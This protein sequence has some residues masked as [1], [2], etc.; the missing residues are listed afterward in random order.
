MFNFLML[1]HTDA[2]KP[3]QDDNTATRMYNVLCTGSLKK[4]T[5]VLRV[6][7]NI[8][9]WTDGLQAY[10]LYIV[11][12]YFYCLFFKSNIGCYVELTVDVM[13]KWKEVIV[14]N[15]ITKMMKFCNFDFFSV[16]QSAKEL[17]YLIRESTQKVKRI[18]TD[19]KNVPIPFLASV[20]SCPHRLFFS[21]F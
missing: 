8:C 4:N 19:N 17:D 13:V 1:T 2:G 18:K 14:H 7:E 5:I 10:G 6:D 11:L 3:I 15:R 16:Q 12:P 9:R 20:N 21:Y